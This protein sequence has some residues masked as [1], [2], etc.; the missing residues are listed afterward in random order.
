MENRTPI[1]FHFHPYKIESNAHVIEKDEG[2]IRRRYLKGISSGI[3]VDQ[4]GERM[5]EKCIK[6][7]MEQANSGDVLLYPDAHGIKA[8]EDIGI[9]TKA[10][11]TPDNE[12]LTEYRLYDD[13][14]GVGKNTLETVDKTWRQINGLPPYKKPRQKGFSIEGFI[15]Q[16]HIVEMDAHGRRAIDDVMLDGVLLVPRPAY[17]DSIAHAIYKALGETAPWVTGNQLSATLREQIALEEMRNNFWRKKH[18]VMDNLDRAIESIM[19]DASVQDK[20]PRL[21]ML[22][23]EFKSLMVD[24]IANAPGAFMEEGNGDEPQSAV[25]IYRSMG[26]SNLIHKLEV[27]VIKLEKSMMRRTN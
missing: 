12:W 8:S 21:E 1:S 6:S 25:S 11:I 23:D 7:F 19:R 10:E 9:L 20:R 2:G 27:E 4:H 13:R 5:T 3:K 18:L 24:I 26:K 17:K 15:P 14:D 16:G 22:F